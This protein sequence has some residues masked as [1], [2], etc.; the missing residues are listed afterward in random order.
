[1]LSQSEKHLAPDASLAISAPAAT[2]ALVEL[3]KAL[4]R[5]NYRFVTPTPSTI[6]LVNS[7]PGN[8]R[9]RGL[10]D[11][12]GWNRAFNP[13]VLPAEILRN[14]QDAGVVVETA[15]GLRSSVR[16]SSIGDD[17][18]FHSSYP[19]DA[20]DAVFFGPDTYRFTRQLRI[21]VPALAGKAT[22]CVDIGCGAG[23]GAI[24]VA[25]MR[26]AASVHAVDINP[27]ALMLTRVNAMLANAGNVVAEHS[28]MLGNVDGTFDLIV[29]NPPYLVDREQ[30]TYRHGGANLGAD[31]SLAVTSAAIGR[32]APG[33]TLLLYTAS[34]IVDGV[35]C[36]GAEIA[37]RLDRAGFVWHYDEVDPDVFGEELANPPYAGTDRIAA[38]WLTATK[39]A[40]H[41]VYW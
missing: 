38:V 33:G 27:G 1:M 36:L 9:A 34:A 17:L 35:D 25:R 2:A 21:S 7:R 30:R 39:P 5:L 6:A 41:R 13:L 4:K 29:A 24:E 12:F 26:P 16:V 31:L 40:S 22:R 3:G 32:L 28:D 18:Y 8:E 23:A 37:A 15:A 20:A 11:V 10:A 14:M 19:T